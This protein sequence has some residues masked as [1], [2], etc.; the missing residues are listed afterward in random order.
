MYYLINLINLLFF[1]YNLAILAR[2]LISWVRVDP[3][4]PLVQFLYKI[5][6]PVLAPIRRVLP[7]AGGLDFSPIVA[8]FGLELV[9]RLL[10]GFLVG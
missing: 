10:I 7:T 2:V 1:V 8:F 3:H 4:N 5:T 9:R 6:E